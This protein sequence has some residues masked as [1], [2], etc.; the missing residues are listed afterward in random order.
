MRASSNAIHHEYETRIGTHIKEV[1]N[2]EPEIDQDKQSGMII[3]DSFNKSGY[4]W[5]WSLL[6]PN[7]EL[8]MPMASNIRK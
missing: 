5:K 1:G 4:T 2:N 8:V 3:P 6:G 7:S